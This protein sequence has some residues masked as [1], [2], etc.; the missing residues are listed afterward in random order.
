MCIIMRAIGY[1]GATFFQPC[2][3]SFADEQSAIH[4]VLEDWL[5]STLLCLCIARYADGPMC[6]LCTL[7]SAFS[8]RPQE[9]ARL[10]VS[11]CTCH[12]LHRSP[13]GSRAH[14][15]PWWRPQKSCHPPP[16]WNLPSVCAYQRPQCT[17]HIFST[18]LLYLC[19]FAHVVHLSTVGVNVCATSHYGVSLCNVGN[20]FKTAL[21]ASLL[22]CKLALEYAQSG[23][24][25]VQK[26]TRRWIFEQPDTLVWV[27]FYELVEVPYTHCDKEYIWDIL[28][29]ATC[30]NISLPKRYNPVSY[31]LEELT[32]QHSPRLCV[33]RFQNKSAP[34]SWINWQINME[35]THVL[36]DFQLVVRRAGFLN[37]LFWVEF[38]LKPWSDQSSDIKSFRRPGERRTC[39]Q[40]GHHSLITT[41]ID[42]MFDQ[43]RNRD[44]SITCESR[45]HVF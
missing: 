10:C 30:Y 29:I 22:S 19:F 4:F 37:N 24:D 12:P 8:Y 20:A 39:L 45:W 25:V 7:C 5:I 42:K 13:R 34:S 27:R 44:L 1:Y 15:P 26:C 28:D 21:T 32:S 11:T 38:L 36:P 2:F 14:P 43:P 31:S 17:R 3:V 6:T 35:A 23:W 16:W 18:D 33:V 9:I 40:P 41:E